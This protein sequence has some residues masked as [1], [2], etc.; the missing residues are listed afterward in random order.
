MQLTFWF[1]TYFLFETQVAPAM[2]FIFGNTQSYDVKK[3]E[4]ELLQQRLQQTLHH[5][6]T[7]VTRLIN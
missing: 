7:Q 4:F 6:Q 3:H 1:S 2:N 5:R